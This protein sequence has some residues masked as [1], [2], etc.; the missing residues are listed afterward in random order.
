[1]AGLK[2]TSPSIDVNNTF[3][4]SL[5][6]LANAPF[7]NRDNDMSYVNTSSWRF[8]A[9]TVNRIWKEET[10]QARV[11][12]RLV[13]REGFSLQSDEIY[14]TW[15]LEQDVSDLVS[16]RIIYD[17]AADA[18]GNGGV[19]EQR[20]RELSEAAERFKAL[21]VEVLNCG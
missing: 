18:I 3:Y 12:R 17:A 2:K 10:P 9:D 19:T 20:L 13:Q 14:D 16:A 15:R 11:A 21:N 7:K 4:K 6:R 1:M 5:R 8:I